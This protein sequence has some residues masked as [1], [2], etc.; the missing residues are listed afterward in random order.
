MTHIRLIL[1][2]N[3][4]EVKKLIQPASWLSWVAWIRTDMDMAELGRM[5]TTTSAIQVNSG[6]GRCRVGS[7]DRPLLAYVRMYAFCIDVA[8]L[9]LMTDRH[10]CMGV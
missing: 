10:Q 3:Q 2:L 7:H 9:D 1:Y 8:E 5:T 6:G 4:C